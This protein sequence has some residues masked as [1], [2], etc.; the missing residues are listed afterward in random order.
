MTCPSCDGR[1]VETTSGRGGDKDCRLCRGHDTVRVVMPQRVSASTGE[2]MIDYEPHFRP[3]PKDLEHLFP[4]AEFRRRSRRLESRDGLFMEAFV[5]CPLCLPKLH[6]C[7][8]CGGTGKL[9]REPDQLAFLES[10]DEG[11]DDFDPTEAFG[12]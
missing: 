7:A 8:E 3:W 10:A 4:D 11:F 5:T 2:A 12:G 6:P 9:A 1:K